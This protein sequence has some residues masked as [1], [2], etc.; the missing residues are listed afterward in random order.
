MTTTEQHEILIA[1]AA[2]WRL[3]GLLLERPRPGW[4]EEIAALAAEVR[5]GGAR[6]AAAT[7]AGATEGEYLRLLGPGGS[8][9][10]RQVTYRPFED[11]G[12]I[13]ADLAAVYRAFAFQPRTEES[14]DHVA[15]EAGFVGYLF[16]KEAFARARGDAD[17]A[18]MTAAA[19][20]SFIDAHLAA[21]ATPFAQ[22]V[23]AAGPSYLSRPAAALASR[24]PVRDA[25]RA[26][27][28]S[29][30]PGGCGTS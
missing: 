3:I 14:I 24:V 15:V 21:M 25:P 5:D 18:D 13:L 23:S 12:R 17:A 9:S 29:D 2:E 22:R 1:A 8:V 10:P 30:A 20:A 6:G 4:R 26:P 27:P 19:R 7:V 11:P 28:P 16:L